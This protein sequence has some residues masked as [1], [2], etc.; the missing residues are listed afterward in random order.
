MVVVGNSRSVEDFQVVVSGFVGQGMADLSNMVC[1][2]SGLEMD[3][4]ALSVGA[5]MLA[6]P[7][8]TLQAT[9]AAEAQKQSFHVALRLVVGC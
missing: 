2:V 1:Q 8:L 9:A 3:S 5:N 6:G 7:L 4:L